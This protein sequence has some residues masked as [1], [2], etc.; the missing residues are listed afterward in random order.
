M[1]IPWPRSIRLQRARKPASLRRRLWHGMEPLERRAMLTGI[2]PFDL[3]TL[4]S[5]NGGDGSLGV[6]LFGVNQND[7]S[8]KL[9]GD[10]NGDGYDDLVVGV[11]L[12]TGPNVVQQA[13]NSYVI[14]GKAEWA[15]IP[16]VRLFSTTFDGTNG[17]TIFGIDDSD[18]SG[19]A[20]DSAG[21]VNG[22]GF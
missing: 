22:D 12:E 15:T 2:H 8:A 1:R 4:L 7:H 3:A 13:G 10:V 5:E 17:F 11:P 16:T 21:D 18:Q 19:L 6:L 14:F 9:V 20:V